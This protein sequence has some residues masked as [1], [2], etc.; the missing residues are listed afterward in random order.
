MKTAE[1]IKAEAYNSSDSLYKVLNIY[2][3]TLD[4]VGVYYLDS[5]TTL[6]EVDTR[7]YPIS[8][9]YSISKDKIKQLKVDFTNEKIKEAVIQSKR[10]RQISIA[11]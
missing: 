1:E 3:L 2:N 9:F 7:S 6:E 10:V 4:E 8:I 11:S 5:K